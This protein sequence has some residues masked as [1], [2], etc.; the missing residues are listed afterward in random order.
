MA[1]LEMYDGRDVVGV[2]MKLTN[3]G[4]G[5]SSAMKLDPV[6]LHHGDRVLVLVEAVVSKVGYDP[7]TPGDLAGPLK[8][9]ATLKAEAAM[10]TDTKANASA[11]DKHKGRV[12]KLTEIEGQRSIDE[13][14]EA[15][16]DGD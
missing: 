14:D 1:P 5:L 10:L 16:E 3:A 12:H 2:A 6:R 7:A 9:V 11:I 4:D 15:G 13:D 8:F